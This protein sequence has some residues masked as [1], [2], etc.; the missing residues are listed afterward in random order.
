MRI[1]LFH[2]KLPLTGTK[3]SGADVYVARLARALAAAGHEVD[4]WAFGD[5]DPIPGVRARELRPPS[6]GNSKILRQYVAPFALN[7]RDVGNAD[8][9][10][11]FG[12]DTFFVRRRVPTVRTFLG[13]ALFESLSATSSKRRLNQAIAFRFEQV[14]ARLANARYGIGPDSELLY[15]ADGTL[16]SGIDLPA[17]AAHSSTPRILFIGTWDG[18]KRGQLLRRAFVEHVRPALPAAELL[19]VSDH[20]EEEPGITWIRAPSEAELTELYASSRTFCLPS[21]YEGF[22]LPYLEAMSHGLHVVATPNFGSLA[23]LQDTPAS[24]VAPDDLGRA[25]LASLTRSQH[26][27]AMDATALRRRA[28]TFAW[29]HVVTLHEQA[30]A[31]AIERFSRG[32]R[33]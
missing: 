32:A 8:V 3:P 14:A 9:L 6:W 2:S 31:L 22:G 29:S 5:A 7:V 13:S 27:V 11:L 30:Y 24:I 1:S 15:R 25:L 18:R 23:L 21:S 10:H 12:D 33:R 4:T 17:Q 26:Q 16:P 20:C 19:M 28:A